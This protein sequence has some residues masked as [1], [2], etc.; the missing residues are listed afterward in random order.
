MPD[1]RLS[2]SK[3]IESLRSEWQ[4]FEN[5]AVYFYFQSYLWLSNWQRSIGKERS[6]VPII[7]SVYDNHGL[8]AIFPFSLERRFKACRVLTWMGGNLSDYNA[9]LFSQRLSDSEKKNITLKVLSEMK[10]VKN[11]DYI[12]LKN[13]PEYLDNGSVNPF[14]DTEVIPRCTHPIDELKALYIPLSDWQSCYSKVSKRIKSDSARLRRRLSDLGNL[15]FRIAQDMEVAEKI[16]EVMI[17]QKSAR[18]SE[19]GVRNIFVNKG[20]KDFFIKIG[21]EA[22]SEGTMHVSW[23][24]LNETIIAVHWGILFRDRLYWLMPSFNRDYRNL[25]PG[26]ILMEDVIQWCCNNGVKYFDFCLGDENYKK[27]WTR[28]YMTLYRYA[29]PVSLRGWI[30]DKLYKKLRPLVNPYYKKIKGIMRG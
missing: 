4:Q 5:E 3:D 17:L 22:Y 15:E 20:Y 16:T 11:I 26:R 14:V 12:F 21:R 30:F 1:C 28:T 19:I 7:V 29:K 24:S 18:L 10:A 13:V 23:L 27:D 2:F 6:A 8:S 25:A 9:P